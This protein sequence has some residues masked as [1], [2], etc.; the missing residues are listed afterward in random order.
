MK[1]GKSETA[2][3]E[4]PSQKSATAARPASAEKSATAG[5]EEE[6]LEYWKKNKIFE[7]SLAKKAPKGE[8]VFYDGPPFATGLP[9]I[10][11]L[12]SSL[13]KDVVPRY[14]TMRGYHVRR[15]WGW[16]RHGLPIESLIE[17]RLNLKTKKDIERIGVDVFNEAARASVLEFEHEW[18]RYV[19]RVG[20][21]VDFKNSY[22]TMDNSYIESVWWALK[23]LNDIGFLYEGRKVLMY[24]THCET[25]LAKAEIAMDQ[26]Y[27]DITEEAVT[28][29][30]RILGG[31]EKK[32][33]ENTFFLAWTTTPWTLPG[34]VALAVGEKIDYALFKRAGD[35]FIAAKNLLG[36]GDEIVEEI[37]GSA[38]VGL[39]YEPLYEIEE[40]T[41]N[42]KSHVIYA[43]N[44]VNTEEGTGIVHTAVMYGEDD[45]A[46]GQKENLP[47][48]QLLDAS[49]KF[50]EPAPDFLK[51]KYV[52]EAERDIKHDLENRKL[53]FEKKNHTHSYPHCYRCGTP[54]IYNAVI[55]WF[56]NIQDVKQK[57]LAENEKINWFPAHLKHGRFQNIVETAPDWTIS[58]NRFWA[59]PLP[60]WKE[61][62]PST[63]LGI[64]GSRIMVIGSLEEL[65]TKVK[66]S[67]NRYFILRHGEADSNTRDIVNGD[68]TADIHL[69][70]NGKRQVIESAKKF[71]GVRFDAIYSSPFQR[72]IETAEIFATELGLDKE[73]IIIDE[74]IREV[75]IGEREG[76]LLSEFMKEYPHD[77]ERFKRAPR[78]GENF[79]EVR[80]R[81]GDF[82]Y[83]M[84][85]SRK[86]QNIL[87]VS[88]ATPLWMLIAAA[89]GYSKK[90]TIEG[91]REFPGRGAMRELDFVPLPVNADYELDLHRP[92]T[93]NIILTDEKAHEYE[94]IPE[95]VDCWV[96]S[97]SMPFAQDSDHR[98]V[99][100]KG[101][102]ESMDEYVKRISYPGDFIAEYIAQTRTW[103]Y[104][105]HAMGVLLFKKHSFR[106]VVTTGTILAEDGSKMSK[107]KG[108]YTDPLILLDQ[109]GADA[110][111]FHLLG[112]VVMQAED[113]NFRDGD[114]RDAH[115]RVIGSLWNTYKFFE[116]YKS[117]YDGK[118]EGRKSTHILDRWVFERLDEVIEDVTNAYEAFDI[119]EVCRAIR[120]F[121]EDYSTWYVRRSRDRI[122]GM[123]QGKQFTLATQREVLG[124]FSKLIA[125]TIPFI[126]ES[127]YRGVESGDSVHI[128]NWPTATK[129]GII[130][131]I[132]G[133][134]S[135]LAPMRA[136]R[137]IVSSALEARASAKIRVRQPLAM[138]SISEEDMPLTPDRDALLAVIADE[139]NVKEMRIS[140]ELPAGSINLDTTLTDE[141]KHEGFIRE[142]VRAIQNAR[143]EAGLNPRDI[144]RLLLCAS[145]QVQRM[146][147]GNEASVRSSVNVNQI[148]FVKDAL[149]NEF[150]I[151]QERIFYELKTKN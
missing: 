4:A 138:L 68:R 112:S 92:Y 135:T 106:N 136:A 143:K 11:N 7:R 58:R 100:K 63:S 12:L 24:C 16:D 115:N 111:R 40:I 13:I 118:T 37:K 83:E 31:A 109:Y 33:P 55:S 121:V 25:P 104:Y 57:M 1:E 61:K 72:T 32:W 125:P 142:L 145:A 48:V 20:R 95:V 59:S 126:A 119:P 85:N 146:I 88:H 73:K 80:R 103:F 2:K 21:W 151:D 23:R 120:Q 84:E 44:F 67:G 81:M 128:E 78:G 30:F 10:G 147:E 46:L 6:V 52:K 74:R 150:L 8:F 122:K 98:L 38:L 93:D 39:S 89:R 144:A 53:L 123:T 110:F 79:S 94:R 133:S 56:I 149:P 42:K 15:R 14:K 97:G 51:G 76:A 65:K 139:V 108:N 28:V 54:L 34:N 127:I 36:E 134:K 18:E 96:E 102:K 35:Y 71:S 101:I 77:V 140:K 137:R 3:R 45:F 49:G 60:I 29:K 75:E 91:E 132:F 131:R 107:S 9:H 47:M 17:K 82:L 130:E 87:I 22:K 69:T 62:G 148:S 105:M 64:N 116:L 90:E 113:L 66:K 117:E 86:N 124:T 19:E 26:T 70:E 50:N 114:V 129:R 99:N 41:K 5:R 43:A 141:L 27:K